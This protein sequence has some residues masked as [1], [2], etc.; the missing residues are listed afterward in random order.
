DQDDRTLHLGQRIG[1]AAHEKDRH[2]AGIEAPRSDDHRIE[3]GDRP[4]D[5]RMNGD[6][7]LEPDPPHE[8][9]GRL[10]RVHFHFPACRLAVA[11]LGADRGALDRPRPPSPA[12]A[13]Q[14][15]QA[16]NRVEEIA[17]VALHHRQQQVAAGWGAEA[18]VA[19]GRQP[20][21]Q[22]APRFP[23]V[24]GERERA[25]ENVAGRQHAEL[26]TQLP[27]AA[28]AVEHRD[29][30]VQ[31]Q[32]GI[33]LQ[34]AEKTGEP[35]A[36]AEAAD[37]QL[38][39]T[40]V[41]AFYSYN[42][43]MIPEA[44]RA[45]ERDLRGIFGSRLQSLAI[46]GARATAHDAAHRHGAHAPAPPTRTLAVVESMTRDDLRSA[47]TRVDAWH[48]AGLATP[49]LLAAREFAQSLDAFPLE[50]GAILADHIVVSGDNP[51][52]SL[53]VDP[54]DLRRA[55]EVQARSHL[56]HLRE[57][58]LETRGRADALS[59]LILQSAPPF[60]ALVTSIA[61]LEGKAD[62][63]APGAARH[64]ERLVGQSELGA[65]SD[66]VKLAGAHD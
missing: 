56:L 7:R 54:A 20:R 39:Q 11:V 17:A 62:G 40:H 53:A 32:P 2:Q 25:L 34:A 1:H 48:D 47:A 22:H 24:A 66:V 37:V 15:P 19:G 6:R 50:F 28:A 44:V 31:V 16:V 43:D 12:A 59:L 51:F 41:A 64:V 14:R 21:E 13:E 26:V 8:L 5:A 63:D 46:Y 57:G 35:G 55:V 29:D 30:R 23:R 4:G 18:R 45:L 58:F 3:L 61:R 42:S 65:I 9:S 52:A 60:A 36:A 27:R 33:V 49:L 38:A 10:P